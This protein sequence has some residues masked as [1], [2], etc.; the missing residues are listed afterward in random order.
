MGA[1]IV[2]ITG[3][4]FALLILWMLYKAAQLVFYSRKGGYETD[5]RLWSLR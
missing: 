2:V 3:L 5:L 1:A 4:L